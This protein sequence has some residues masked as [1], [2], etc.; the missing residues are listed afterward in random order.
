MYQVADLFNGV[1]EG[2][3]FKTYAEAYDFL[4]HILPDYAEWEAECLE[5]REEEH[6][7]QQYRE[8]LAV[9]IEQVY[10]SIRSFLRIIEIDPEPEEDARVERERLE[11]NA[12]A[13]R[14]GRRR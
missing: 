14:L 11:W 1:I 12:A 6:A 3:E 9:T 5:L 2:A 8:P 13:L 10:A 4:E 7:R